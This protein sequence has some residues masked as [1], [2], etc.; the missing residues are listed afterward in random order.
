MPET[1]TQPAPAAPADTATSAAAPVA[2]SLPARPTLEQQASAM[3]AQAPAPA[4]DEP[5]AMTAVVDDAVAAAPAKP[6]DPNRPEWLLP[7]YATVEDQAKAYV[8]LQKVLGKRGTA[9][10]TPEVPKPG[11]AGAA[12]QMLD[13]TVMAQLGQEWV[14]NNGDL[15]PET[16]ERLAK[17]FRVSPG[18]IKTGIEA[19]F[20]VLQMQNVQLVQA[21]GIQDFDQFDGIYAWWAQSASKAEVEQFTPLL[22]HPAPNVRGAAIR[23]LKASYDQ[24]HRAAAPRL[25]G[26]GT[27]TSPH[28]PFENDAQI[29]E[30]MKDP[31]YQSS[32]EYRAQVDQRI[33]MALS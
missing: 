9:T 7:K 2:P 4:A 14:E 1:T 29:R 17:E 25:A 22:N 26:G 23:H 10:L 19:Q 5:L 18:I 33:A 28:A 21:A 8:D 15:K 16:Y 12:P 20:A 30:A 27:A 11:D 3:G 6:A 31:R 24:A 13:E 32:P